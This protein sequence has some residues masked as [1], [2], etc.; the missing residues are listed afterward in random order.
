M[1]PAFAQ[2]MLTG[3][4]WA[5]ASVMDCETEDSSLMS[6]VMQCSDAEGARVFGR[7]SCAVTLHPWAAEWLVFAGRCGLVVT[8][9]T[10][11]FGL[12]FY[13]VYHARPPYTQTRVHLNPKE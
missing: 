5:T 13:I 10:D 12:R 9:A 3:P 7:L 4:K 6:P 8:L 11:D 1:I 2:R